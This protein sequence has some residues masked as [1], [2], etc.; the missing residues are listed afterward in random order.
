MASAANQKT[1]QQKGKQ[2][3]FLVFGELIKRGADLYLPVIDTG[4]DAL[5]R[6]KDG[7]YLQIQVKA[8]ETPIM[9]GCFNVY[10]LDYYA[11]KNF[12][13]VGLDLSKQPPETWILPSLVFEKYATVW[14]SKQGF[15]RY[16]LILD[17]KDRKHGNKLRRDILK[18]YREAWGLLTG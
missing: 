4:I 5:I 17:Y 8:T 7:T 11:R 9:A 18:K 15:K 12:F 14:K 2:A 13:I 3:E 1:S 6:K 16:T 10:D